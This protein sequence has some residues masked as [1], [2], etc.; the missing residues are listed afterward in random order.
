MKSNDDI[1]SAFQHHAD[2]VLRV[3]SL[4]FPCQHD[5]EDAF[6]D[7]FLKYAQNGNDFNDE[8]HRKAWLIRVATNTCKDKLKS[9]SSKNVPFTDMDEATIESNRPFYNA[10]DEAIELLDALQRLDYPYRIALFLKY[11]EGYTAAEI[12]QLLDIPESTVY[13]NLARGRDKL[14]EALTNDSRLS[15]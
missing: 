2:T 10:P 7:T 5:W 6:Q 12:G 1:T 3:C 14:K 13:T 15:A 4:Y 11:Y 9:A 8:E